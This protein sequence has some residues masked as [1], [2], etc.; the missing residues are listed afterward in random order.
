MSHDAIAEEV[1]DGLLIIVES[2]T[3]KQSFCID[4]VL[5]IIGVTEIPGGGRRVE[6]MPLDGEFFE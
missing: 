6:S 2:T 1:G 4:I 5:K 3:D